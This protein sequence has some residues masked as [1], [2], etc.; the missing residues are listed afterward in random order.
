M[1]PIYLSQL[2]NHA[3]LGFVVYFIASHTLHLISGARW[4]RSLTTSPEAKMKCGDCSR[5][6]SRAS[7]KGTTLG[8]DMTISSG[9]ASV[10]SS[11]RSR[12]A[13][14]TAKEDS[15]DV[16]SSRAQVN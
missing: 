16:R 5:E 2:E 11:N 8:G 12:M 9:K 10:T 3:V 1:L 14:S 13:S 4:K 6:E 7:F 15:T